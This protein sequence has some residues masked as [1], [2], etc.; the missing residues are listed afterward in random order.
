MTDG[1]PTSYLIVTFSVLFSF[2]F[3]DI[4]GDINFYL[5]V[6]IFKKYRSWYAS[7]MKERE[8]ERKEGGR[9]SKKGETEIEKK[10][11]KEEI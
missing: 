7:K 4:L 8:K 1:D 2:Y 5:N 6:I 9:R 10:R 3:T 11:K